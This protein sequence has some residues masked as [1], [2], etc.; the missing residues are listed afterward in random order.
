LANAQ[1]TIQKQEI[2]SQKEMIEKKNREMIDS[3][4][5]ASNIQSAILPSTELWHQL[6][7]DS[8]VLYRPKDIVSGDF[9]WLGTNSQGEVFFSVVDCTGHGVPG[10]LMSIVGYNGLNQALNEHGLSE[11]GQILDYLSTSV[12]ES[13]RKSEHDNYVRDGMDIALGRL[14]P[15]TMKLAFAGAYNP[16]LLIRNG[17][18][19]LIKGDRMAIGNREANTKPFTNHVIDVLP[20][21]CIY[22][23]SDG[24][25]D[26]FGGP[27]GKKMKT[28]V[29]RQ[30]VMEYCHLPMAQQK[31]RLE[32]FLREWQGRYE[33]VDDICIIGIRI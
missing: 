33:Q 28:A 22:V 17:E 24:Y 8:F 10:A 16:L 14:N 30:K 31:Q 25:A 32:A 4:S 27:D 9:Y 26:Q 19:V 3:I 29:M 12:N 13:L 2:E 1:I 11:P 18:E 21:D 15:N 7:P 20:G 6:L 5:Y 23:Y